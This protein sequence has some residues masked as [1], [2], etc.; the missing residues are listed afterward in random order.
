MVYF[1]QA[2]RNMVKK[3]YA[4]FFDVDDVLVDATRSY[5]QSII[6]A[7]DRYMEEQH[8]EG[9]NR[10]LEKVKIIKE[11]PGFND[12][13][14]T[15]E[16]LTL[17]LLQRKGPSPRSFSQFLDEL[18]DM[19]GRQALEAWVARQKA[20][21][22][23][24]LMARYESE[25]VRQLAMAFYGGPSYCERL[26]GFKAFDFVEEGT[27]NEESLLVD[28]ER[29]EGLRIPWFIYTGRSRLEME[30]LFERMNLTKP[31]RLFCSGSGG[32][33][34]PDPSPLVEVTNKNNAQGVILV[35]DNLDDREIVLRF[36]QEH[37]DISSAFVRVEGGGAP[38]NIEDSSVENVNQFL[39]LILKEG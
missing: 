29:L 36:R 19:G 20:D 6:K 32:P 23:N 13:W 30:P 10:L 21:Q 8:L 2:L 1:T 26:F 24:W 37:P 34:K 27:M 15:A 4:V 35:G 28:P 3:A 31:W 22:K 5:P 11:R 17:F 9:G 12:D 18:G 38:E 16:A 7:A 25:R 33:V 39:D 14:D